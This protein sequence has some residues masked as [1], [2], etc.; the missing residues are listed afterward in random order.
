MT[1]YCLYHI[2]NIVG[3]NNMIMIVFYC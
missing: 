3:K 2:A 1:A